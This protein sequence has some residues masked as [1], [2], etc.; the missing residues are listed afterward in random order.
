METIKIGSAGKEVQKL[1]EWLNTLG[2]YILQDGK[3]GPE[4]EKAV[5]DFQSSYFLP[6]TGM[7]DSNLFKMFR[8]LARDTEDGDFTPKMVTP[9]VS[10]LA[11]QPIP[12][13][14][15]VRELQK[16]GT[17]NAKTVPAVAQ[18]ATNVAAKGY[19]T[20]AAGKADFDA[21]MKSNLPAA[22]KTQLAAA[23]KKKIIFDVYGKAFKPEI[24]ALRSTIQ[25]RETWLMPEGM[26]AWMQLTLDS[27]NLFN[28]GFYRK[29]VYYNYTVERQPNSESARLLVKAVKNNMSNVVFSTSLT[30]K[31]VNNQQIDVDIFM[32]KNVG[33]TWQESRAD[34]LESLF[35]ATSDAIA[36]KPVGGMAALRDPNHGYNPAEITRKVIGKDFS[37]KNAIKTA[38][39]YFILDYNKALKAV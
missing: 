32:A 31:V 22:Q 34:Y 25:T 37:V 3:Y 10:S 6:V 2:Y 36:P 19:T 11:P 1:Q 39:R 26:D 21:L 14:P 35:S 33:Y 30:A 18:T 20:L 8:T 12:V 38:V 13:N 4:D 29:G 23:M 17:A 15:G 28:D 7:V 9:G 5:R 27:E 24:D 16:I